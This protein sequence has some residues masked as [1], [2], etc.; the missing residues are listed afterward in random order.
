MKYYVAA[1]V[2]GFYSLF[3]EALERAGYFSDREERKLVI[4]GDLFDRGDEAREMQDFIL[5]QMKTGD[6]ILIRGNHEDLFQE[7]VTGDH[8]NAY[9]HHIHNGT[10]DTALQLTGFTRNM[11]Q[12]Q[13]FAFALAARQTP[14]YT[15]IIPSMLDYYETERYVFVH[16][17][18][19]CV[20]NRRTGYSYY[21]EWR[22]VDAFEWKRARWLNGMDAARTCEEEK[23][24]LC[25]HW[26][27][28]YGHARYENKGTEFGPDADF[29]PYAA[30]GIIALDACTAVSGKVNVIVLEDAPC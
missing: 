4:L 16:G 2:H 27:T 1:D 30:P 29:S 19:P 28:S 7:L 18:I 10:Y 3:R 8:G 22:D 11:A 21:P 24:I 12:M 13:N 26:H 25:G 6:L 23:T 17:W 5:Q 14:Y 20:A 15:E 9:D